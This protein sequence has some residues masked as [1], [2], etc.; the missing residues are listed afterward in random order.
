MLA[1]TFTRSVAVVIVAVV[2]CQGAFS[3][4]SRPPARQPDG[5]VPGEERPGGGGSPGMAQERRILERFDANEDGW[6]NL[7]ERLDARNAMKMEAPPAGERG[8]RRGPGFGPAGFGPPGMEE[9]AP[10]TPG[11][12]VSPV[13]VKIYPDSPLY[14]TSILRTLFLQFE[15]DDW[16]TELSDFHN[17]DVDVPCTLIVDGTTYHNVGVHF[18]G[19][20]SYMMIGPGR[21]R[22]L[23]LAMDLVHSAQRLYGFKTLN[24]LNGHG[25]SSMMSSVLFSHLAR[26]H[27]PAP[28]ANFVKV[29]INGESWG[30]YVSLEQFNKDFVKEYF[31]S[32]SGARW[33]V[34]GSPQASAGLDY[35]GD[36]F[37]PYHRR[38]QLKSPENEDDWHALVEL[39]RTLTETPIDELEDALRPMLD[40]EGALWFLA[41]DNALVN[42]DG[43]WI[44]S[45]DYSLYRDPAG[46]FHVIP[47]DMNE[48]FLSVVN[49]P[50]FGGRGQRGGRGARSEPGPAGAREGMPRLD[51]DPPP[52][53]VPPQSQPA[54]QRAAPRLTGIELDPLIGMNDARK[55][56]RSRLLAVP[57]LREQY[58]KNIREIAEQLQ[59]SNL[60]PIVAH[61]RALIEAELKIDTRKLASFEAF[62]MATSDQLPEAPAQGGRPPRSL[63]TF[64]EGRS[65]FLLAYEPKSVAVAEPAGKMPR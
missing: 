30:V 51:P 64:C 59:W 17:T 29:V 16:E 13:E 42:S 8:G 61:H 63:R 1:C 48:A 45:S 32:G 52:P 41:L 57:A 58:L 27:I 56:L 23:N 25:D 60:G 38:Y 50:G 3:Q 35:T 46:V 54:D 53:G 5:R 11:P 36:G 7:D 4:E 55:P 39:C 31:G 34:K 14:D 24:L 18:R 10:I 37:E 65:K 21:K 22:S 49:G 62:A 6:L 20:S 47:H 28:R 33:K 43:Y 2:T 40:I 26:P 12:K 19:A 9:T 44:R 15:S